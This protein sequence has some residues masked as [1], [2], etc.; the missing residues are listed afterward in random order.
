MLMGV[1]ASRLGRLTFFHSLSQSPQVAFLMS[2]LRLVFIS[3]DIG[4]NL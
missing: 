3:V 1:P 2:F 4:A